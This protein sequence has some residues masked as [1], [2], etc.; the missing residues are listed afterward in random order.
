[1]V[2]LVLLVLA[3]LAG[4]DRRPHPPPEATLETATARLQSEDYDQALSAW[5]SAWKQAAAQH[6]SETYWR[7]RLLHAEI[8]LERRRIKEAD[9]VLSETPPTRWPEIQA[10]HLLLRA[11]AEYRKEFYDNVD[12]LLDEAASVA[13]A[14]GLD[15]LQ[16]EIDFRRASVMGKRN[17]VEP[18]LSL[19]RSVIER[20]GGQGNLYLR[21]TALGNF[22]FILL[23]AGR[24]DEALTTFEHARAGFERSGRLA[25]MGRVAGNMGW[26]HYR[27]GDLDR[28]V[29][30]FEQ[31]RAAFLKVDNRYEVQL[32]LGNQGSILLSRGDHAEAAEKYQQALQIA[33][34]IENNNS[35]SDWLTNLAAAKLDLGE[36]EAA[37]SF[38]RESFEIKKRMKYDT[39]IYSINNAAMIAE[40]R[41]NLAESRRLFES[42]LASRSNHA[43]A[44]LDAYA[45]LAKVHAKSGS[46]ALAERQYR[47]ALEIVETQ[48]AQLEEIEHRLSYLGSL[49]GL[50][51]DYVQFLMQAGRPEAALEAAESSRARLLAERAGVEAVTSF[52]ARAADFQQLARR[53]RS[54]LLSYWLGQE[55]S[56]LWAITGSRITVHDLP[57]EKELQPLI[58]SY[59]GLIQA[60]RDPLTVEHPAGRRL[61]DTLIAPAHD[62][63]TPGSRVI[64]VPDGALH[65]LNF[66][67]LPAP[68]ANPRYWIEDAEITL[69]PSLSLLSAGGRHPVSTAPSMLLIGDPRSAGDDFPQLKYA[70]A[71]MDAL[72]AAFPGLT[73]AV[74]RGEEARPAA[75]LDSAPGKFGLI[76]FAAHAVAN[77]QSP[78]DSAVIL[79]GPE[80]K[81]FA[82]QIMA[83]PLHARLVTISACRGA[84]ARVYAG[85]G[86]VGLAWAFL[87]AGASNVIAGLWNV[88]DRSTAKLMESIYRCMANGSTPSEA[89]R[90]GKR[91]LIRSGSAFS[92]PYYWAPF[93]LYRRAV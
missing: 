31:A 42:A 49:I 25:S 83:E 39:M 45:G 81:L 11:H 51:R 28:A 82:R 89:L 41:G 34:E 1:M 19:L 5:E 26:C 6:G 22:G 74:Y 44:V 55:R 40:K 46:K 2:R 84:G 66:E 61:Y 30:G 58:E 90:E 21:D 36:I 54:V 92:K 59:A 17:Q 62:V 13:A 43:S 67:S 85:E 68:G 3:L 48:R 65:A 87:R 75:Y 32:W 35:V 23:S 63:L 12:R 50:Y 20:A 8:L 70:A 86:L 38:N 33:R 76:H 16:P 57:P 24:F 73:K 71:E 9:Q 10:R 52:S 64:I 88:D 18:A 72:P 80:G 77:S 15:R 78:L 56:V 60:Q 93:Q 14:N 79:S 91:A 69:A 47:K 4:C 7:F 37:E 27:L 53:S 29:A